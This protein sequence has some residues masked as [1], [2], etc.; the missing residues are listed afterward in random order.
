MKKIKYLLPISLFSLV[1]PAYADV[2]G[3]ASIGKSAD[4]YKGNIKIGYDIS[5]GD[6]TLIPFV[7]YVNYFT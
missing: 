7:D 6:I 5:M 1:I 4:T 2:C 3:E